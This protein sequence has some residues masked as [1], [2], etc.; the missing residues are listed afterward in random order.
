[1][2]RL[3]DI[4][5]ICLIDTVEMVSRDHARLTYRLNGTL[6]YVEL[7][8]S[9]TDHIERPKPGHYLVFYRGDMGRPRITPDLT[10]LIPDTETMRF[11][12]QYQEPDSERARDIDSVF[13]NAGASQVRHRITGTPGDVLVVISKADRRLTVAG[14]HDHDYLI[15]NDPILFDCPAN[16]VIVRTRPGTARVMSR[17]E[18]HADWEPMP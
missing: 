4:E 13:A 7:H 10:V 8:L 5:S 18:F 17:E 3:H 9:E 14:I 1:M 16:P 6:E 2:I 12:T 11:V 15:L